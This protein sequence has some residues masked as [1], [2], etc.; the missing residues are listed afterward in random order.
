M[1]ETEGMA[2]TLPVIKDNNESSHQTICSSWLDSVAVASTMK[3]PGE[4]VHASKERKRGDPHVVGVFNVV[5]PSDNAR[6]WF[7]GQALTLR[8]SPDVRRLLERKEVK[9]TV[10][11]RLPKEE[12]DRALPEFK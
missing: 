7:L 4:F 6:E 11:V 3:M 2:S 5:S 10:W 8:G 12:T 9:C 1:F